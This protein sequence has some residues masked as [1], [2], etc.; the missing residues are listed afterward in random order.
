MVSPGLA[1][2]ELG[3]VRDRTDSAVLM[4]NGSSWAFFKVGARAMRMFLWRIWIRTMLTSCTERVKYPYRG[5]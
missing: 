5:Q 4:S 3:P 2:E 1:Q